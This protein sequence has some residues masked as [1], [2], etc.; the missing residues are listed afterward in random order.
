MSALV[1]QNPK[2]ANDCISIARVSFDS[3]P[4]FAFV[5]KYS[6]DSLATKTIATPQLRGSYAQERE[7]GWG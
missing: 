5:A 6:R 2:C 1:A 4:V 7:R 3:V